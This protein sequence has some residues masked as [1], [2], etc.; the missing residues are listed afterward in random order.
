MLW[1]LITMSNELRVNLPA[2]L[3]ELHS[4]TKMVEDFG[5]A[6]KLPVAKVFAVNL[7]LD[8]LISNTVI[9]GTFED[10]ID[11]QIDIHLKVQCDILILTVEDNGAMF[12]PTMDTEPEISSALEARKVGGLGLH[13][14]KELADRVSYDFV[15]GKNRLTLEHDLKLA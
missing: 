6:N 15:G 2:R 10:G 8:E 13:L 11:P 5:D 1:G 12:N 3:S 9:H 14:V 7:E 4:L